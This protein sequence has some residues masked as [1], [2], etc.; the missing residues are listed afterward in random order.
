M[1]EFDRKYQH[2]AFWLF[3]AAVALTSALMLRPFLPAILWAVVLAVLTRPIYARMIRRGMS[4]NL[5]AALTTLG[6]IALIGI[7]VTLIGGI[8]FVQINGFVREMQGAAP[9]GQ[10]V[11][12]LAYL[13]GEL[14]KALGPTIAKFSSSFTFAH[15]IEE[16]RQEF[17]RGLTG[18]L[19]KFAISTGV[20]AFTMVVA[21]LTMFF[22][23]RDGHQVKEPAIS[24]IP[25]PRERTLDILDKLGRTIHAVFVSV[26]LVGIVQG[27]LAGIGY[28]FAGVPS[29]LIWTVA[30]TVLCMIPLLGAPIVYIPLSLILIAQGNLVAGFGLLAYCLILVSNIDNLLKPWIIGARVDLHPMAVFFALLGGLFFFGPVGLMAGPMMLTLLLAVNDIL[31]E[32]RRMAAELAPA[33]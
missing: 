29:P 18:P 24:L 30:T 14:D 28:F 4:P 8:L 32:R 25:L 7:P 26:F 31:Q 33:D 13:A 17:A 1:Q 27:F 9:A 16:N 12:D 11:F 3:V 21:F 20:T 15:W 10:S 5:A 22:L 23:L 2:I 6:T 19:G